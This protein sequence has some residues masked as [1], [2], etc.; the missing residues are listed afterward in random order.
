MSRTVAL[1]CACFL[2][3]GLPG[4]VIR[5]ADPTFSAPLLH[6]SYFWIYW[7]QYRDGLRG[8]IKQ[9]QFKTNCIV[10]GDGQTDPPMPIKLRFGLGMILIA[11]W[12][13][14]AER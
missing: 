3:F 14:W 1:V 4:T 11:I 13:E 12:T 5:L 8:R 9:P 6:A 2:L 10:H 7:A